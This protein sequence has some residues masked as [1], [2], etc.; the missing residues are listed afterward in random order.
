MTLR[1]EHLMDRE[2]VFG[3]TDCLTL[4]RDIY[5]DNFGIAITNYARPTAFWEHGFNLYIQFQEREGFKIVDY[6]PFGMQPGD[7]FVCAIMTK[8]P[9]HAA[10]YLGDGRVVHHLPP[11]ERQPARRGRP[12]V[13]PVKGLIRNTLCA[14]LR[15][16]DVVVKEEL[17]EPVN[18][19]ESAPDFIKR[20]LL[21][22]SA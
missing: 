19:I 18:L 1:Y 6:D 14:C 7:V 12:S 10:V 17:G 5:R 3:K 11:S 13:D 20:R 22:P 21:C 15:H 9:A 16:G 8:V 4:V 2:F